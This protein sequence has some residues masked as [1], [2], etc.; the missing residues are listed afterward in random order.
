MKSIF[1][2]P[3]FSF[4]FFWLILIFVFYSNQWYVRKVN[5]NSIHGFQGFQLILLII[6]DHVKFSYFGWHRFSIVLFFFFQMDFLF[7]SHNFQ[8][9]FTSSQSH[10]IYVKTNGKRFL[11]PKYGCLFVYFLC[12]LSLHIVY[13]CVA[14]SNLTQFHLS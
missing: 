5:L 10:Y 6:N 11:Y 8:I 9:I 14:V 13:Q 1:I 3:F 2:F 7:F 4:F 12:F